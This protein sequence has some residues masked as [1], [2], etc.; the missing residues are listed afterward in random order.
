MLSRERLTRRLDETRLWDI[1]YT[2]ST[3]FPSEVSSRWHSCSLF[4]WS[5][6]LLAGLLG[7]VFSGRADL[8]LAQLINPAP[9]AHII[10]ALLHPE[11]YAVQSASDD[12]DVEVPAVWELPDTSI[13]FRGYLEAGKMINVFDWYQSFATVLETRRQLGLGTDQKQ[14]PADAAPGRP[15]G[16]QDEDTNGEEIEDERWGMEV[17]AR[18]IR[19]VHELDFMGFLKHTGRKADHVAR[20]VFDVNE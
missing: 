14:A 11:S 15:S 5:R 1:W 8:T 6:P 10:S 19:G 20:T 17:Q 3:P 13:L 4:V 7:R 16:D 18:F 2:G 9:R 12:G